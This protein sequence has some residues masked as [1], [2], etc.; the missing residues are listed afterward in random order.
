MELRIPIPQALFDFVEAKLDRYGITRRQ[1]A[2]G[3]IVAGSVIVVLLGYWTYTAIRGPVIPSGMPGAESAGMAASLE[4]TLGV[5]HKEPQAGSASYAASANVTAPR[6]LSATASRQATGMGAVVA[7]ARGA[8][9]TPQPQLSQP[10]AAPAGGG[11][12]SIV[13]AA[14][15]KQQAQ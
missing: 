4:R 9:A 12:A 1:A 6:P 11:M 5:T 10:G 3:L 14:A 15:T 7:A 8:A 13:R 2:R